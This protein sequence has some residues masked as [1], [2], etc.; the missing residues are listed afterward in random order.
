MWII[1]DTR[2]ILLLFCVWLLL[3]AGDFVVCRYVIYAWFSIETDKDDESFSGLHT[4]GAWL[5]YSYHILLGLIITAHLKAVFS[6]PGSIP[7]GAVVPPH[8]SATAR[9]CKI[10]MDQWKPPR[11]HHCKTCKRCIFRMD[12][13]CP[14]INNCVGLN[15]QKFFILFLVY[16]TMYTICT[17]LL[18]ILGITFWSQQKVKVV[19]LTAVISSLVIAVLCAFFIFFVSD[20]LSEQMESIKTNS[21]LVETYQYATGPSQSFHENV[22]QVFGFIRTPID[23]WKWILPIGSGVVPN[24]CEQVTYSQGMDGGEKENIN[25]EVGIAGDDD[26]GQMP[27]SN[28]LLYNLQQQQQEIQRR[29]SQRSK[30]S[31]SH[32]STQSDDNLSCWTDENK[33]SGSEI[34]IRKRDGKMTAD[35]S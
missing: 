12:H 8:Q 11:A 2:G 20:F 30:N 34:G 7:P 24:L 31:R 35:P 33:L 19:H 26:E 23:Y 9:S 4:F 27:Q 25:Q 3:L 14:W 1:K 32:L 15:N 18:L 22:S 28:K 5:F 17:L 21:T 13:H 10:C 29:H 6:D 16:V